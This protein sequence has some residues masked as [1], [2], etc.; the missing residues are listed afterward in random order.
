MRGANTLTHMSSGRQDPTGPLPLRWGYHRD[1]LWSGLALIIAGLVALQGANTYTL[2]LLGLGTLVHVVGW[3]L[4]P[5][6]GWTRVVGALLGLTATWILLTGP[7][8]TWVL[9]LPLAGWLLARE[10]RGLAWL[11]LLLPLASGILAAQLWT[12]RSGMA[13]ALALSG[14]AVVAAAW[15]AALGARRRRT[16]SHRREDVR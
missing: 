12:E 9:V 14:A 13:G 7:A 4:L 10:R 8:S 16:S 6:R 3:V 5:A 1:R 2:W 15:L 11:T